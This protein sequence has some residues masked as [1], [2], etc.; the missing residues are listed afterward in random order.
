M[1]VKGEM[2]GDILTI[3]ID[4][5]QAARDAARDSKSGKSRVLAT[6]SGFVGYGDVKVNLNATIEKQVFEQQE[7]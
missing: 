5:S 7:K 1:N 4:C 3:T 2:N 6:T